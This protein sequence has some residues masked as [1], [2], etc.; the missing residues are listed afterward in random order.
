[1]SGA[2]SRRVCAFNYV[3][4]DLC[5]L[6]VS[7]RHPGS[8]SHASFCS[9]TKLPVFSPRGE[10]PHLAVK[11]ARRC[12]Q[13]FSSHRMW[14][15]SNQPR[16][17]RDSIDF[18]GPL[19]S[20]T[21]YKILLTIV[22][23]SSRSPFVCSYFNTWTPTVIEYLTNLFNILGIPAWGTCFTSKDLRIHLYGKGIAVSHITAYHP[24]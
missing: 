21:P 15:S 19:P 6:H 3:R 16:P 20:F 12:N 24:V 7:S 18:K 10:T 13:I 8:H 22:D 14:P 9:R 11:F 17:L 23:E 4:L 1:M 2:L 5:Q